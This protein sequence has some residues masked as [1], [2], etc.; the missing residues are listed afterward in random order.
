MIVDENC[1]IQRRELMQCRAQNRHSARF[2]SLHTMMMMEIRNCILIF[3]WLINFPSQFR[4]VAVVY[5]ADGEK[6]ADLRFNFSWKF[7][8]FSLHWRLRSPKLRAWALGKLLL[9]R[10]LIF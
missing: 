2:L 3:T 7:A 8:A 5:S 1:K 9:K 6:I 10:D 4:A